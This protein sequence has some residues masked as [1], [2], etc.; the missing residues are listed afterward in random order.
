MYI[1][2]NSWQWSWRRQ[3][4]TFKFSLRKDDQVPYGYAPLSKESHEKWLVFI[5]K[6]YWGTVLLPGSA[7]AQPI[8]S[9]RIPFNYDDDDLLLF[10]NITLYLYP[11]SPRQGD[12]A[13]ATYHYKTF[14]EDW[15]NCLIFTCSNNIH[16]LNYCFRLNKSWRWMWG[17]GKRNTSGDS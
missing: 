4:L 16:L 7:A 15:I 1:Q 10:G 17:S 11:P 5:S 9:P 6:F 14:W 8:P 2:S 3:M 13:S 12:A